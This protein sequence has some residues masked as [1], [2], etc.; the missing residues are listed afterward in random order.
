MLSILLALALSSS[1]D[2]ND[3][4]SAFQA[5]QC[6]ALYS[7]SKSGARNDKERINYSRK[8]ELMIDLVM[9]Y[10][11]PVT[12]YSEVVDAYVAQFKE[13]IQKLDK[14]SVQYLR[15]ESHRCNLFFDQQHEVLLSIA[16]SKDG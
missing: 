4:P 3:D 12:R 8:H 1:L 2:S 16:R 13:A 10:G 9:H 5:A 15:E 7:I 6:S 14:P 11:M